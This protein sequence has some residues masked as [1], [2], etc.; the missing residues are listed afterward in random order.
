MHKETYKTTYKI[1]GFRVAI[2]KQ[3]ITDQVVLFLKEQ[4]E[5]G[6]G[7]RVRKLTPK[8]SSRRSWRSAGPVYAMRFSS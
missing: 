1:G 5:N 3:N 2:Q 8:I 6:I 7:C 4:I